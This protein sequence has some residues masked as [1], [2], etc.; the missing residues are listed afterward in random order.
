MNIDNDTKKK[1]L[2]SLITYK[3]NYSRVRLKTGIPQSIIEFVDITENKKYNYTIEGRGPVEMQKYIIAVKDVRDGQG[4]PN[5][6][7]E[8]VSARNAYDDG[9][10]ELCTGRDGFNIL[11]YSIP[12][13][14]PVIRKAYFRDTTETNNVVKLGV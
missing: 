13:V 11:L 4:W 6:S 12:R 14:Q 5:K 3:G 9:L 7:P 8:I 2:D 1:I 10:V